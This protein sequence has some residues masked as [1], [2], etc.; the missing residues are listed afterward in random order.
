MCRRDEHVKSLPLTHVLSLLPSQLKVDGKMNASL[1]MLVQR[2]VLDKIKS[3]VDKLGKP[4]GGYC[5]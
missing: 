4:K 3:Q 1:R 5:A 2:D